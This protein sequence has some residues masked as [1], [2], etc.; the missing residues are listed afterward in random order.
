MAS[1]II[2][3]PASAYPVSLLR[4]KNFLR[5]DTD[6]DDDL[7]GNVL[8]PAATRLCE[9]F[10]RRSFCYKGFVQGLDSFPY[11]VD[12][13]MS[14]QAFPPSYYALPMY[15]TT[16]WNYSQMIKLFRPP[17]VSVER[18]S[19]L[20]S[21]DQQWHDLT[22]VP[23]LWFPG[24]VTEVGD[25]VMDNNANVQECVAPGTTGANPPTWNTTVGG[26][27]T[28]PTDPQGEGAGPV[29]W[30]N[31][32]PLAVQHDE[33][34]QPLAQFGG[35]LVDT[36]SEPGRVFPGPPGGFWPPILYVPNSVRIHFTAGY[37]ADGTNV[38]LSILAA[39]MQTVGNF[40]ENRE[41]AM[42]GNYA[43]LPQ[44]CEALLW[45]DRVEDFQPTRG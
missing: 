12:T 26:S 3:T 28:E 19:F 27:T 40:Y 18:I 23:M 10:T 9:T 4:M 5:V 32:G 30:E 31:K 37:S 24:T 11:F 25:Q 6:A 29:V 14:Q 13:V 8:I 34:G 21:D 36:E 17:L 7:I 38:P 45:N 39:I 33:G 1:L 20:A 44:H 41:A 42:L 15:S 16:L 22:P 43:K 35:F 2:E